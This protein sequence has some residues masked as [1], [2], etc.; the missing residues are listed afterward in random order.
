MQFPILSVIVL[1]PIAA[2]VLLLILPAERKNEIRVTALAAAAI[3][4]LLSIWVYVSYD[5]EAGGYQFLE[6]YEWLPALGVSYQVGVDGISAPLVLLTG[7]VMF[8]GVPNLA[9][10]FGYFRA[11]WTPRS[12]LIAA[13]VCRLLNH[14][15][16]TG[17]NSVAPELRERDQDMAIHDWI[18]EE[19]FNPNYLKRALSMLPRRG[20]RR[21]WMHTQDHWREFMEFPEIDLEDDVFKYRWKAR[22]KAAA[23]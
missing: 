16:A 21:E 5:V 3:A 17:A 20:D 4:L 13:F 18:D 12:E 11:S 22:S 1:T 15:K 14:M 19:N 23:S 9:W 10:V 8:T 6:R 2:S 7:V